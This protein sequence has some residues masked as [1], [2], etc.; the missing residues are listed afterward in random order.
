M[1]EDILSEGEEDEEDERPGE[2][3][4]MHGCFGGWS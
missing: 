4:E 2:M 3:G 1:G